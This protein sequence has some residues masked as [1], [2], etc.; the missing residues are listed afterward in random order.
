MKNAWDLVLLFV[1]AGDGLWRV[2]TEMSK[3]ARDWRIATMM[4]GAAYHFPMP[5]SDGQGSGGG[6]AGSGDNWGSGDGDGHGFITGDG[7][8]YGGGRSTNGDGG[9]R[10]K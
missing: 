5:A 4:T 8:G 9:T 7:G 2:T 1:Y 6:G 3:K 10:S